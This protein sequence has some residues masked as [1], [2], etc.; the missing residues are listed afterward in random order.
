MPIFKMREPLNPMSEDLTVTELNTGTI[1]AF[2]TPSEEYVE[3]LAD[4][5]K[6]GISRF[7]WSY[8]KTS[9]LRI[10]QNKPWNEM[11]PAE[12]N[13]VRCH[14]LLRIRP[15]DWIVHVNTPCYGQCIAVPV[16]GTYAFDESDDWDDYRHQIPV[17]GSKAIQFD[18][19]DRRVHPLVSRGLKLRRRQ[20]RVLA[21]DEFF[22]SLK[23][24]TAGPV[25]DSDIS[26]ELSYLIE[27]IDAP[28]RAITALIHRT[29]KEKK[30]EYLVADVFR[31]MPQV[32]DVRVNG[33]GWGTDYGVSVGK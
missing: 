31:S 8:S 32:T 28:L 16:I 26:K 12:Q 4:S 19:N 2:N 21:A 27:E 15:G 29:H 1:W 20:Q 24:L 10:L 14:F 3:R 9:D 6:A 7:G 13:A 23:R 33:S 18:R 5:A 11:T 30:L 25:D 22:E 17:D